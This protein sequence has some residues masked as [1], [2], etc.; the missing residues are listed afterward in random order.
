MSKAENSA[1][2]PVIAILVL[3]FIPLQSRRKLR[4]S[5][6]SAAKVFESRPQKTKSK[7]QDGAS[8][9]PPVRQARF[10]GIRGCRG[11]L[12]LVTFLG[13][14]RKVTSRRATPGQRSAVLR[15]PQLQRDKLTHTPHTDAS[16]SAQYP[17]DSD[18]AAHPATWRE[19]P[20]TPRCSSSARGRRS[21]CLARVG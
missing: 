21:G 9:S 20:Q 3:T 4:L 5:G 12:L 17:R 18:D 15:S 11:R 16:A 19:F 6:G 7:Q 2:R 10:P 14:T 8:S 13:E 1:S